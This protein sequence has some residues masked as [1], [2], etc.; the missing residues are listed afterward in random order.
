MWR[1]FS[2]ATIKR[3]WSYYYY[4]VVGD[5]G[6][7]RTSSTTQG[8]SPAKSYSAPNIDSAKLRNLGFGKTEKAL[9][10][11]CHRISCSDLEVL[12][13]TPRIYKM[14]L[15]GMHPGPWGRVSVIR[16]LLTHV[17]MRTGDVPVN[18][19]SIWSFPEASLSGN[20]WSTSAD[21]V[22][23]GLYWKTPNKHPLREEDA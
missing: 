9:L 21:P 11:S 16:D 1:H 20:I 10:M 8:S 17:C 15:E 13:R 14:L 4:P 22:L 19:L 7:C 2:L 5:Q 3:W 12:P 23:S 18:Q 6:S